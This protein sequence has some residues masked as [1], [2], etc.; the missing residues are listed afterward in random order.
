MDGYVFCYKALYRVGGWFAKMLY[1]ANQF[2]YIINNNNKLSF[3]S[4]SSSRDVIEDALRQ[5]NQE[6]KFQIGRRRDEEKV[7]TSRVG[8]R[9][10]RVSEIILAWKKMN[11]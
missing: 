7:T 11:F 8:F 4:V 5:D 1:N 6:I 2:F 10:T 3:K 9:L